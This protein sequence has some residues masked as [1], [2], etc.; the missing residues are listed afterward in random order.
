MNECR[1]HRMYNCWK[2]YCNF[3]KEKTIALT[4][5]HICH[6]LDDT[7]FPS[8]LCEYIL[9]NRSTF[10]C[11]LLIIIYFECDFF[12]VYFCTW[13]I[14]FYASHTLCFLP[15]FTA[16]MCLFVISRWYTHTAYIRAV[17]APKLSIFFSSR[18]NLCVCESLSYCFI[19]AFLIVWEKLSLFF[20]KLL[21]S[22]F[23]IIYLQF[24]HNNFMDNLSLLNHTRFP[25]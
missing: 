11:F 8:F 20:N 10:C 25:N 15:S 6:L 22:I 18:L 5:T 13:C 7:I 23:C 17:C 2:S 16:L 24:S 14:A 12:G 1:M 9:F 3:W 4:H 19:D 21:S